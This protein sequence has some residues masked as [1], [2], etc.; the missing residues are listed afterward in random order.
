MTAQRM[1]SALELKALG[2]SYTLLQFFFLSLSLKFPFVRVFV[3]AH[4]L[5]GPRAMSKPDSL[6]NLA[7]F[8]GLKLL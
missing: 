8:P 5:Y 3:G 1:P 4:F 2:F 7:T 6:L